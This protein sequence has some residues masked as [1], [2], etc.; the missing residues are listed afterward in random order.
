MHAGLEDHVDIRTDQDEE[1]EE[2]QEENEEAGAP[3]EAGSSSDPVSRGK[4][5]EEFRKVEEEEPWNSEV[6]SL[7]PGKTWED[8]VDATSGSS[9]QTPVS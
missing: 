3:A 9:E 7:G 4:A 5:K 6:C 8:W 1:E 2:E